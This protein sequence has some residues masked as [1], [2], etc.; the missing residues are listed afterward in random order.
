MKV[1]LVKA[2][3]FP[4][5]M[6]GCKCWTI[7][8]AENIRTDAFKL[9]CWR[10]CLRVPWTARRFN[11][12]I[13]KGISPEDSL[14]YDHRMQRTNSLEKTLMLGKIEGRWRR[15]DRIWNGWKASQTEW[16]W[17]WVNSG[18]WQWTGRPGVLQSMR[19]QKVEHD[20]VTEL[21]WLITQ[22][23]NTDKI[24]DYLIYSFDSCRMHSL[25]F[26]KLLYL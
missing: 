7:K 18:S 6:Y 4:V 9:W 3:A 17:V 2:T 21:N 8:N 5:V 12:S 24:F 14:E 10:R 13:L 15:G 23:T 1:C 19:S 20:S 26:F 11:H 16:T 22:V 25:I